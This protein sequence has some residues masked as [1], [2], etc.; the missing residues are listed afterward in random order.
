MANKKRT[1]PKKDIKEQATINLKKWISVA[2]IT[3][4]LVS[5]ALSAM[6]IVDSFA[7]NN[8]KVY[9]R[10]FLS[11]INGSYD[12]KDTPNSFYQI[13]IQQDSDSGEVL[14]TCVDFKISTTNTRNI[15]QI[16]INFSDVYEDEVNIF[17]GRGT[18]G[19][20]KLI[21]ELTLTASQIKSDEDGW[22][23]LYNNKG[24]GLEYNVQGFYGELKIGFSA[25]L[26]LREVVVVDVNGELFSETK[27]KQCTVGPKPKIDLKGNHVSVTHKDKFE[28]IDM[29]NAAD[30][31]SKFPFVK[32]T[33]EEDEH[34]GHNH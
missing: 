31:Q 8:P 16:W 6:F 33:E 15:S 18:A 11:G 24:S 13:E 7:P 10:W 25:G 9:H 17:L 34:E 23:R 30:E 19:S 32:A 3:F 12:G 28:P 27:V 14:Y 20:T 29:K 1:A 5:I 4:L 2:L 21:K 26:K 22:F